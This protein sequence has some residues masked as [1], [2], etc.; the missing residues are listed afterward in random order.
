M[1]SADGS[2]SKITGKEQT[3][4]ETGFLSFIDNISTWSVC[5]AKPRV[6]IETRQ[7]EYGP[8]SHILPMQKLNVFIMLE[9]VNDVNC[10]FFVFF[11]KAGFSYE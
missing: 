10:C 8:F 5:M 6:D 11:F 9:V 2:A 4:V 1:V 3:E 7:T